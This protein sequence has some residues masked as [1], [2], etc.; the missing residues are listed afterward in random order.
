M[1]RTNWRVKIPQNEFLSL[2]VTLGAVFWMFSVMTLKWKVVFC[3]FTVHKKVKLPTT[4][5]LNHENSFNYIKL[6]FLAHFTSFDCSVKCSFSNE[7]TCSHRFWP[8]Q[9]LAKV[10]NIFIGKINFDHLSKFWEM[11]SSGEKN[12]RKSF[13]EIYNPFDQ[14]NFYF[15]FFLP[16]NEQSTVSTIPM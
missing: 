8:K 7:K 14:K 11:T 10:W 3:I 13:V 1:N 16:T 15:L 9:L 2:K 4:H 12:D 6:Q 5:L